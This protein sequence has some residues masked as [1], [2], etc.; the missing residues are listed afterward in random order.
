MKKKKQSSWKLF[1]AVFGVLVIL[2]IAQNLLQ[3]KTVLLEVPNNTGTSML[4]TVGNQLVCVFLDGRVAVWN[5]NQLPQ[6]QGNF[7]IRTNRAVVISPEKLAAVNKTGKKKLSVYDL[8]SGEKQIDMIVGYDDQ[9]VWPCI[10]FDRTSQALIRKNKPDSTGVIV[11][12]FLTVNI[13]EDTQGLSV[14]LSI[15][16]DTESWIDFA[17]DSQAILYAAGS[18]NKFGR[19]AAVDLEKGS[20]AWDKTYDAIQEFCSIMVSPQND[21]LLIGSRNGILYKINSRT[22]EIL[23]AIQLLEP[24]ETRLVT[25]DYSVLNPAFSPDGQYYVVTI[26]PKVYIL[27][28]GTDNI[29]HVTSPADR[30]ISRVAFS[31]DSR[32]FA[33][34]DIR[35]GFPVK[36]WDMP[37]SE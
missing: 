13:E 30:L 34:S 6:P 14:P 15:Q 32:Y 29:I 7:S 22:G 36:I 23:K 31:P 2:I 10:S 12:E 5:W 20:I 33:T 26:N 27:K 25:N 1:I 21:Y 11:Y 35:A 16:E 4:E 18:K 28:S 3:E 9:E 19:I 37:Q 17:V 24:G 8:L